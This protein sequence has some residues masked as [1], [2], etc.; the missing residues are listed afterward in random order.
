MTS[1]HKRSSSVIKRRD[2]VGC[3]MPRASVAPIKLPARA[4]ARK[5]HISSHKPGLGA[6]RLSNKE[7]AKSG[8][9]PSI[10]LF[11]FSDNHWVPR[12]DSRANTRADCGPEAK[13]YEYLNLINGAD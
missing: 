12:V 13:V 1:C 7:P 5:L 2:R 10:G 3:E 8:F 4:I 11:S 9:D 6:R